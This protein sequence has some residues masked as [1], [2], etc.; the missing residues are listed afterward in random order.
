MMTLEILFKVKPRH[1]LSEGT[2]VRRI[3]KVMVNLFKLTLKKTLIMMLSPNLVKKRS[4]P[5]C[6]SSPL[7]VLN[8]ESLL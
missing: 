7:F 2:R 5:K 1:N 4:N 6:S 8:L 3:S